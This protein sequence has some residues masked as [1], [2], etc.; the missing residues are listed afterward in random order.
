MTIDHEALVGEI[1]TLHDDLAR[2]LGTADATDARERFE[3]QV[4]REFS[5]VSLEGAVIGREQL[6]SGLRGA[7]HAAPGLTIDIADIAVLHSSTDC[8]V[9]RFREIHHGP[10]GPAS[11][12]TTAVLLPDPAARNGLRWR[13]VH[14]TAAD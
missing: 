13:S 10:D 5:M 4:H 7:G 14:E 2:W 9:A 1:R 8:A 3:A 11:R 6:L 12:L